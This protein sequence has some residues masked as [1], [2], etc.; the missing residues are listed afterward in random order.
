MASENETRNSNDDQNNQDEDPTKPLWRYVTNLGKK[1]VGGGNV[2]FQCKYCNANFTGTYSR[3]KAH[4][5]KKSG[6]GIR[7]CSKVRSNQLMR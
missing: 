2:G 4:L 6:T 5:L 1:G 7:V 3:V